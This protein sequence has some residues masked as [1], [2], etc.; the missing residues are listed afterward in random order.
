MTI[1]SKWREEFKKVDA[2]W[3]HDGNPE[4]PHALLTSNNH[5]NGFFNASKVIECPQ[6]LVEACTD[7][8]TLMG[9]RL[10]TSL[11][12]TMVVGSAM[13]AVTIAYEIARQLPHP[14]VRALFTEPVQT[15]AGKAMRLKRFD[16]GKNEM[17]LVVE[18]VMTTGGTTKKTIEELQSKGIFVLSFLGVLVNRS[19]RN[20]LGQRPVVG[21]VNKKLPVWTPEECPLCKQGSKAVR[22]KT[23]W[24]ELT[25]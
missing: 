16:P 23:H 13:G 20:I 24:Q 8:L 7:L 21:L 22:P 6:L 19:G 18:D 4:K 5:S 12:P 25:K 1:E 11:P 14:R 10:Y 17:A 3:M 9:D 15:T 2:L